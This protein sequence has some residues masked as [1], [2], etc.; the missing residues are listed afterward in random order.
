MAC[1]GKKYY[2]N[3]IPVTGGYTAQKDV[4]L[5]PGTGIQIDDLSDVNTYKFRFS[6]VVT[7]DLTVAL[8]LVAKEASVVKTSPILKGTVIDE[9]NLSWVYNKVIASQTLTNTGGLSVPSLTSSDVVY[10]Y[11]G[12]NIQSGMSL[13]IDGDDGLM[14]SG[15]T[16][17]DTKSISF[18]NLLWLGKGPSKLNQAESGLEA[19]L[20]TLTSTVKTSRSHTY[21]A[22]GST[23]EK[24]FVAYPASFGLG[25]F[26]KGIFTGGY[27]RLKNVAGTLKFTLGVGDVES[28]IIITNSKGYA[29]AYYVYESEYDAQ[30]DATTSFTIS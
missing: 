17:S 14:Q 18:G 25:T 12:Q 2:G 28:D 23:N 13:T 27:I 4:V 15:S 29:E 7:V 11:T 21:F 6:T 19:F 20:E 22:T 8:T 5:I 24:H 9:L 1:E 10:N 30:E 26:T 3:I 16:A